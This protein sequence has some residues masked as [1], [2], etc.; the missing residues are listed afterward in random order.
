MENYILDRGIDS[1]MANAPFLTPTAY[2]P[3]P[4]PP[5]PPQ[6]PSTSVEDL[7]EYLE[8]ETRK[9][10]KKP[11]INK[12]LRL[13]LNNLL[14]EIEDIY[15]SGINFSKLNGPIPLLKTSRK[16]LPSRVN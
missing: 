13:K 6:A 11:Y 8:E 16:Y 3:P 15:I 14:E 2:T 5:P 7:L 9:G 12:I 10:K 1:E 4:P